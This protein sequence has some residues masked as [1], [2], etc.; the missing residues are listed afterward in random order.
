MVMNLASDAPVQ[1]RGGKIPILNICGVFFLSCSKPRHI[2]SGHMFAYMVSQRSP[3]I[4]R[5]CGEP[6]DMEGTSLQLSRLQQGVH[7]E[8]KPEEAQEE[9]HRGEAV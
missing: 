7:K 2:T 3:F 5:P 8:L 9:P 4:F 1:I 6:E